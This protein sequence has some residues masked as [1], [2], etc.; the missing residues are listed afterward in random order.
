M[1]HVSIQGFIPTAP[2]PTIMEQ[3]S[4]KLHTIIMFIG[5]DGSGKTQFAM[6]QLMLQLKVAQIGKKKISIAYTSIDQINSELVDDAQISKNSIEFSRVTKQANDIL[7][8]KIRNHTSYPVNSDFVI[9]DATGFDESLRTEI[10]SIGEENHYN[11]SALVFNFSDKAEYYKI[12]QA[13]GEKQKPDSFQM[14]QIKVLMSGNLSKKDYSSVQYIT[15][16]GFDKYKIVI[17]D[18]HLY[19]QY[20]LP[21]DKKY[22]I[23]GDI[24]GCLEE[25]IELLKKN[26]FEIDSDNKISH[27][28]GYGVVLVGD[29]IDKGYN[30]KGVVEFV[31]DNIDFFNIVIG[32]HE[33]F[34]HKVLSNTIKKSDMPSKVVVDSYFDSIEI[35]KSDEE[36]KNKFFKIFESMKNFYIHKDFIATHVS[37]DNKFLGKIST[38]ALKAGRDFRVPKIEEFEDH[39]AFM[40]FFDER[41]KSIMKDAS[42][43]YPIHVFGHVETKEISK[44][45]NKL[46][47]DTACVAG[48]CLSSVI[49]DHRG[50]I[51]S[52]SVP[53]GNKIKKEE[54]IAFNFFY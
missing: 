43:F 49:V 34:V 50:K 31:Y 24:H 5:P 16:R 9:V 12:D 51:S 33:N 25:L 44:Y 42:D 45:K 3:I 21:D 22:V 18:Y 17:E 27:P 23:I 35:F 10:L 54:T 32:N 8:N 15:S 40:F 53:A 19:E 11:V 41:I 47:I 1:T 4:F 48:G 7:I 52:E 14:K 20:M 38:S 28:Q 29:I 13:T 37:C 26:G 2:I 46:N 6:E 39:A 36:L 30:I